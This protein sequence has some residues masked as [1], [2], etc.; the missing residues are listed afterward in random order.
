MKVEVKII[1]MDYEKVA[2]EL[3]MNYPEYSF[4]LECI[5]YDYEKGIYK[6]Y[7]EEEDKTH[8]VSNKD[9]ET[10]LPL[11]LKKLNKELFFDG[12]SSIQEIKDEDDFLCMLDCSS[13]DAIVQLAIFKD[14]IYG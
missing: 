13:T 8:T 12:L 5:S 1:G 11:F 4:C 7:E 6:F 2:K 9:I 14:V 3:M 10:A